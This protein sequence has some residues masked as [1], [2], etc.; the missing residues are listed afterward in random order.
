MVYSRLA[1]TKN[2]KETYTNLALAEVQK[3]KVL[4]IDNKTIVANALAAEGYSF[5]VLD[6]FQKANASFQEA[7]KLD[8]KS[9]GSVIGLGLLHIK[10]GEKEKAI[11]L[12]Q[13]AEKLSPSGSYISYKLGNIYREIGDKENSVAAYMRA[14]TFSLAHLMLGKYY[15]DD[16]RY[17]DALIE[18]RIAVSLN[19]KLGE[20][21]QNIA[22]T[23]CE[24]ETKEN[25]LLKEA[26]DAARKALELEK[27]ERQRWHRQI[28]V[29]RVL[30]IRGKTQ[31]ALTSAKKS[32]A[33]APKR[34]QAHYYL[35]LAQYTN[36]FRDESQSHAKLAIEL[37]EENGEWQSKAN[38]LLSQ[39][40][41]K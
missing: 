34:A 28:T 31:E 27:D 41:N 15:L 6:A 18:F 35:A 39:L 19:K 9:V 2:N 11:G 33:L 5:L 21:W 20:A 25:N 14:G 12:F 37:D 30:L 24:S 3:V 40:H 4:H 29:S 32:V 38:E 16:Q 22:W 26:E 10:N 8:P 23:I 17:N 7:L 13:K 1:E 36:N